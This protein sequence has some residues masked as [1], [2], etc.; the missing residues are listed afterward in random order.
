MNTISQCVTVIRTLFDEAERRGILLW[1]EN[2]WAI[3]AR[4]G[5]ITREH[6]DIDIA[7]A[8]DKKA[9]YRELL[10]TMGF[11]RHEVTDYG[12]LSRHNGLLLDSEPCFETNGEYGFENFPGGSCPIEKQGVIEGY[13]VRCVS[14]EAMYFEFLGYLDEIPREQW[15]EKDFQSLRLIEA[16]LNQDQKQLLKDLHT[17][18]IYVMDDT[19][20]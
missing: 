14:W 15:R 19:R 4:L 17:R 1:L 11:N 9:A 7:F 8:S 2:G 10:A 16:H 3:D 12:F 18:T 6:E 5:S 13:N 20:C